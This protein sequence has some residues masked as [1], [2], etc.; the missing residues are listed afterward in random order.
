MQRKL[1]LRRRRG[2]APPQPSLDEAAAQRTDALLRRLDAR[3]WVVLTEIGAGHGLDHVLVGPAGVFAI[4]SHRPE[5]A[6]V[7]VRDG[8]LWLRHAGDARADSPGLAI[9]RQVIDAARTLQREIRRRT[10][11]G[12]AVQPVVVLWCEFP[13]GIAESSHVA[14]VHARE[15]PAWL[16]AQPNRLDQTGREQIVQALRALHEREAGAA[17]PGHARHLRHIGPRRRAA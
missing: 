14:F 4:A 13:Q 3:E 15:M 12:P 8:M 5:G 16:T 11:R 7:R 9:N 10:G 6:G 2:A 17:A 1:T